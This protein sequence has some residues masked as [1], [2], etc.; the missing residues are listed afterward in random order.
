MD[1]LFFVALVLPDDLRKEVEALK[2]EVAEK[3]GSRHALKSPAHITLQMPFKLKPKKEPAL[4]DF[5]LAF[6][7][8]QHSFSLEL[9][10]FDFFEPRVVFIDVEEKEELR[11]LQESLSNDIRREMGIMNST[12]K[13]KGFHPHVTI[14]FRDLKKPD[15]YKAREYYKEKPFESTYIVNSLSLLRHEGGNWHVDQEFKFRAG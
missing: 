8:M 2:L 3:F 14:G 12:Y 13:N 1:S 9:A 11:S 15:F 4:K 7:E 6:S 10:G 5:L